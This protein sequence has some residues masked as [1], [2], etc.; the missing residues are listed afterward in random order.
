MPYDG[1][2][3]ARA[4]AQLEK[5][6]AANEAE[7][8]RRLRLV[9]GRVPEIERIDAALRSQMTQLV[10]LTVT[11]P[12]DMKARIAALE[13]ENLE[14]QALRAELLVENGF[15]MDYLDA[16]YDCPKCRDTGNGPS[17]PCECLDRLYNQELTR[18]LGV[19]LQKGDE[20]FER[21][22]LDLY[23]PVY[24]PARG[25]APREMAQIALESCR[26][27]ADNFPKVSSNLL[28]QG[29]PG[30]GKTYLSACIARIVA[31]KGCSV[32][33]DT[34]ASALGAFERQKFAREP[35][36]QEKAARRV[37]R[38]LGCDL[39]ILDDLGTEMV[40]PMSVSALYTL[41]NT[42][43]VNGKKTIISTNCS[44]EQLRKQYGG[45]IYSRLAGEFLCLPFAGE[46]IRL[47]R[48]R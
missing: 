34:A 19:L 42:R 18:E 25:C 40:T 30:L 16:I 5:N 48:S 23:S 7:H 4:R 41:I 22:D 12:A 32:C 6:R 46:D 14:A 37:E 17:G 15:P 3:L 27:F 44:H 10:R 21:F 47:L 9:Y 33:Y 29:A 24:D 20:C 45:Q 11:R 1:Q 2:L 26:K 39:M 35:E 38:M 28:L 13:K 31:A 43:L 36:E 8:A